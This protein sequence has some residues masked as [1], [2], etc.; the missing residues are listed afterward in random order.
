MSITRTPERSRRLA[1]VVHEAMAAFRVVVVTG[2]RQ[3][4]KTTLV[5]HVLGQRGTFVRLDD[6]ATLQAARQDPF[7]L[8]RFGTTPRAFD[9]IQRAG[10]PLIRTIKAVVDDNPAPGQ[11]LLNG[12]ADFLTVPTISES[13]AGRAAFL[14]LWPFTQGELGD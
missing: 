12:S 7:S 1:A 6:E 3:A 8:A 13:L 4:G 5:R 10:D 2:P 11:F 9:E 14:E